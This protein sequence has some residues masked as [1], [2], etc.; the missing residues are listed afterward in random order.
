MIDAFL[1]MAHVIINKAI[2]FQYKTY[3][4]SYRYE[5]HRFSKKLQKFK[6]VPE[7]PVTGNDDQFTRL[8]DFKK[9][10]FQI[11]KLLSLGMGDWRKLST[12]RIPIYL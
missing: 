3:K 12:T 10:G 2:L 8:L 4:I 6:V 7:S 1:Y 11:D 5:L 9:Y